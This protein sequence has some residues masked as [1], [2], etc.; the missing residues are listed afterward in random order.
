MKEI[1][2][3]SDNISNY[4]NYRSLLENG[5]INIS[6]RSSIDE[7][8]SHLNHKEVSLTVIDLDIH[9]FKVEDLWNLTPFEDRNIPIIL[10]VEDITNDCLEICIDKIDCEVVKKQ[11]FDPDDFSELVSG[12]LNIEDK[13]NESNYE[14]TLDTPFCDTDNVEGL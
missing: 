2:V 5:E 3:Y 12:M 13:Q 4:G 9:K 10:I 7:A 11:S 8:V 14:C 1:L 6:L